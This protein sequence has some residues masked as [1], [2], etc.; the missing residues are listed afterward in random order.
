MYG[1]LKSTVKCLECGNISITFDPF[2]TLSLPITKP[3]Y[4]QV[5]FVPYE[6]FREVTHGSKSD[7][8]E[9]ADYRDGNKLTRVEHFEYTFSTTSQTTVADIKKQIVEKASKIG[10]KSI[11]VE[12]LE[13]CTCKYGEVF[14]Q[15]EDSTL[16]EQIEQ[17]TSKLFMIETQKDSVKEGEKLLELNFSKGTP[18]RKGITNSQ[19]S[20]AVP[21]YQ[22]FSLQDS[23]LDIKRKIYQRCAPMFSDE[24]DD[25]W[26]HKNIFLMIKDNTP[27]GRSRKMD[28]EFCGRLHTARDDICEI[29]TDEHPDGNDRE[30]ASAIKLQDLYD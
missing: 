7:S 29:R 12:N 2:L 9:D 22:V 18:S 17:G 6:I 20:G 5:P 11:K 21:R 13:L 23:V 15:F 4:F 25:E 26:L 28:C 8:E 10:E 1:Q 16:V 27:Q 30:A 3:S 14:E 24:A 19:I